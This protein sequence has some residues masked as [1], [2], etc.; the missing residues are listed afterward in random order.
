MATSRDQANSRDRI[1]IVENDPTISDLIGRQALQA[2]GYQVMVAVD[3][4]AAISRAL[5]WSPDLILADLTLPGL[6]GKDLMI[7]LTSQGV[8]TPLI[9]LA[10][11]GMEADLI[12]AFRLGAVDC[13]LLPP[14]EAE[15]VSAVNRALHQ[16]HERRDRE[17]LARQLQQANQDLQSRVREL[18]T[19]F[20]LGKGVAA[21]TDQSALPEKVL[22]G[23]IRSTQADLGW[24][25]LRENPEKP[26]HVAAAHNLPPALGVGINTVWDDGISSL[27]AM[28]G[29][30]LIMYGEQLNRFKIAALGLSVLIVPVKVQKDVIGLLVM[31]RLPAAPFGA[32][33]Q[34]L[35]EGLA[36]YASIALV[37]ARLF[38]ALQE[39]ARS[40]QLFAEG[41][42]VSEKVKN[43]ILRM[44]KKELSGSLKTTDSAIGH[45]SQDPLARW[46]P[47]QRQ[48][49]AAAQDQV[50]RAKQIIEALVPQDLP[51]SIPGTMPSNLTDLA[52]TSLQRLQVYAQ[53][54][55][56]LL[57][58]HLPAEPLMANIEGDLMSHV[59]DALISN[60]I[61]F[62][63]PGGH[64]T[65]R[66]EKT[67]DAQAH[68]M[69]C[70]TG[71]VLDAK[72]VEHAFDEKTPPGANAA[73]RSGGMGI[74]L[75]LVKEIITRQKGK[76][77][78]ESLPGKGVETHIQLPLAR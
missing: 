72:Q 60:A 34:H 3:A 31:L 14:R 12:Q 51:G 54:A 41:A 58:P 73:G 2:V 28:S 43:D 70:N 33:E 1:L 40:F 16:V 10:Q 17:R 75:S 74:R 15:V 45:F 46:R 71:Q 5:Q 53:L 25:L 52:L 18:T 36:D 64:V 27:V 77:W 76:I 44:L 49:L 19:I 8:Q 37:N 66:L 9:I 21:V 30:P 68:L 69:V 38:H 61:K 47:E 6:S 67:G 24:F 56:V 50:A 20:A 39:R 62:S 57:I 23:A 7:A 22:D 32:S 63:Q 11:R 55:N 48:Q 65:M 26:F 59:F 4:A 35:L 29:E 13:L 42:R 78:L